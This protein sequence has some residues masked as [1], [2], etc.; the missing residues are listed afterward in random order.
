MEDVAKSLEREARRK[1]LE[2]MAWQC[3][4]AGFLVS[5]SMFNAERPFDGDLGKMAESAELRLEFARFWSGVK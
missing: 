1:Q 2:Q 5:D 3:F 4:L